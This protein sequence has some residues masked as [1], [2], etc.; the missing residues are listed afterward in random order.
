VAMTAILE[1]TY[2]IPA[3]LGAMLLVQAAVGMAGAGAMR[4][5]LGMRRRWALTRGLGVY[6]VL[7]VVLGLASSLLFSVISAPF[8]A[9][10]GRLTVAGLIVVLVL[11][12]MMIG[13]QALS[14]RLTLWLVGSLLDDVSASYR[15]SIARMRG[16]TGAGVALWVLVFGGCLVLAYG[17]AWACERAF[18]VAVDNSLTQTIAILPCS[19]IFVAAGAALWRLCNGSEALA[20]V[21]D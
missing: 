15:N 13:V 7:S 9:G 5:M 19:V 11:S 6:I 18:G 12:A 21:F 10:V 14:I 1:T 20:G 16:A 8:A 4:S 17:A 2:A 3:A